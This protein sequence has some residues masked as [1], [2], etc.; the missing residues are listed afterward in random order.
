VRTPRLT[1]AN[2]TATLAL[3]LACGTGGAYAAGQIA[4]KSVGAQQ[5]RPG[6]VTAAKLRKNAVIAPKIEALAVKGPKIANGAVTASKLAPGS[7][8][9]GTLAE[10]S[11]TTSKIADGSVTGAKVDES[12]LGQVPSA[13]RASFAEQAE[14]AN[15]IAFALV[16]AD[17][18]VEG[19]LSRGIVSADVSQ[20][21]EPGIYCVEAPG[22]VPRGAQATPQGVFSAISVTALVTVGSGSCPSPAVEVQMR[23][24]GALARASFYLEVYR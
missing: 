10:S 24:G 8:D 19:S 3:V 18:S 13:A 4:P 9:N 14:V 15:P 12:S 23:S 20:G 2:V 22:I 16:D 21:K 1:Y 17:G 7:V 5:L 11:V 6:A